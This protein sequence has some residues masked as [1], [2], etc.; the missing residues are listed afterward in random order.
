[1]LEEKVCSPRVEVRRSCEQL[2]AK[3]QLL[4]KTGRDLN[5]PPEV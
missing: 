2:G 3:L 1:M 4:E 5:Y